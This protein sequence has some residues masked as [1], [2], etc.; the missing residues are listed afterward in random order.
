MDFFNELLESYE[1]LKKRKL[2]IYQI[3]EAVS[4][5]RLSKAAGE[6][7]A[8]I[9]KARDGAPQTG[10]NNISITPTENPN[11][12]HI[13]GSN[14]GGPNGVTLDA[15]QILNRLS[16][17]FM[18]GGGGREAKQAHEIASAWAGPAGAEGGGDVAGDGGQMQQVPGQ[19]MDPEA[20]AEMMIGMG[21]SPDEIYG[22]IHT[23]ALTDLRTVAGDIKS[24]LPGLV[25]LEYPDEDTPKTDMERWARSESQA[26]ADVTG[27]RSGSL[28]RAIRGATS[29]QLEIKKDKDGE[30]YDLWTPKPAAPLDQRAAAASIKTISELAKSQI[31]EECHAATT[32]RQSVSRTQGG[33]AILHNSSESPTEGL[34][35]KSSKLLDAMIK[36][37]EHNISEKCGELDKTLYRPEFK[38]TRSRDN[39]QDLSQF[40]GKVL[41][42]LRPVLNMIGMLP[43]LDPET[44]ELLK[45]DILAQME[46]IIGEDEIKFQNALAWRADVEDGNTS[47]PIED[48]DR[49]ELV[50]NMSDIFGDDAIREIMLRVASLEK[51]S[52]RE[53]SPDAI[54]PVG[55]QRVGLGLSEDNIEHF[56][57][58]TEEEAHE[59]AYTALVSAGVSPAKAREGIKIT[60]F[61]E[62]FGKNASLRDVY[63]GAGYDEFAPTAAIK[64]SLKNYMAVH[65][66]KLGESR[67]SRLEEIVA[68]GEEDVPGYLG[69][70]FSVLGIRGA[71]IADTKGYITER[72][73]KVTGT[74]E[75]AFPEAGTLLRDKETGEELS[76]S[77][78]SAADMIIK[79]L[80]KDLNYS[81]QQRSNILQLVEKADLTDEEGV[82]RLGNQLSRA[83]WHAEITR[84]LKTEDKRSALNAL[85]ME[86]RLVGGVAKPTLLEIRGLKEM[87]T[88]VGEQSEILDPVLQKVKSGEWDIESTGYGFKFQ[89]PDS[90]DEWIKIDL[91]S[92]SYKD[93][94]VKKFRRRTVVRVSRGLLKSFLIAENI[95]IDSSAN[96][97]ME[98]LTNQQ[99][100]LEKIFVK[101]NN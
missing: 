41:E 5:P 4:D 35:L 82:N 13:Q 79:S 98:F 101:L 31:D 7:Q 58:A 48:I 89:S 32:L 39:S 92:D 17:N 8:A 67:Q 18:H 63:L 46:D 65:E 15:T 9:G 75:S 23:E 2:K 100:I 49:A 51:V 68:G 55:T 24:I 52:R 47:I 36:R 70:C 1:L 19:E 94:G 76:K 69:Q 99:T 53:R 40:R 77:T 81:E 21:A 74:F 42:A 43:T 60:T 28:E 73:A 62:S 64:V 87:E 11:E 54:S 88:F 44:S 33:M 59:K 91:E 26:A 38:N 97:I 3:N 22:D 45:Q 29:M 27:F 80:K 34:M 72:L 96:L 93:A 25:S 6:V 85:L 12:V 66:I 57:G 37:A 20:E 95:Q 84:A 61:G 90:K 56:I 78:R 10:P 14:I 30:E 71:E 86:A 50:A 16:G 83:F